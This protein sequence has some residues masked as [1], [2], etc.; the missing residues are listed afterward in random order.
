M[1]GFSDGYCHGALAA[2]LCESLPGAK[3]RVR[4]LPADVRFEGGAVL[5]RPS[6]PLGSHD[7][8]SYGNGTALVR[9]PAGSQPRA[10]G[11]LAK[12]CR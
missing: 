12:S 5:A 3:G 9:I 11:R 10:A 6:V 2:T 4:F 1:M 7:V 8:G